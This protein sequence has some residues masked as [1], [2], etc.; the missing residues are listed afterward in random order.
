MDFFYD[1]E[2]PEVRLF[3]RLRKKLK[4]GKIGPKS[5]ARSV[6]LTYHMNSWDV[7]EDFVKYLFYLAQE[8]QKANMY[9]FL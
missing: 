2:E 4:G 1:A 8:T 5:R 3:V 9:N 6:L 7:P